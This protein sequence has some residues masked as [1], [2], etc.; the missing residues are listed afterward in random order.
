MSAILCAGDAFDYNKKQFDLL[1]KLW[2]IYNKVI[3]NFWQNEVEVYRRG[4]ECR[5]SLS[6]TFIDLFDKQGFQNHY[7]VQFM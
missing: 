6:L 5:L 7:Y 1:F 3:F 2:S 4:S